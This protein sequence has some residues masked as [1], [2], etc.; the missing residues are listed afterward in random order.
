MQFIVLIA[1]AAAVCG[2]LALYA[3]RNRANH[4]GAS[5]AL[6][7][8]GVTIWAL[9]YA[10][11]LSSATRD[12]KVLWSKVEYAGIV[13]VPVAWV[14][15]ALR[16]TGH[17]LWLTRRNLALLAAPSLVTLLLVWTNEAHGLIWASIR[18]VPGP[19]FVVW[20]AT[21]GPG[22][23]A[24]TAYAY[25][26]LLAGTSLLLWKALR[27]PDL[28]RGQ[29]GAF[30]AG[31]AVPWA[32]NLVYNLGLSPLGIELAP[33]AF[34]VT[35]LTFAGAL[36]RWRLLDIMPVAHDAVFESASDLVIVLDTRHRIVD[37]NQA[38][39]QTIGR[40][41]RELVGQPVERIFARH[42]AMIG[43]F[44]DVIE[45]SEELVLEV[46]GRSLTY[47]L[48]ITPLRRRSGTLGGRLVVLR[49]VTGYKRVEQELR[50]RELEERRFQERLR[51]LVEIS[52]ELSQAETFDELC[53]RAVE[54]GHTRLGFDRLGLWL[55]SPQADALLGTFGI[56]ERGALRDERGQ[57][58]A[59]DPIQA[60]TL[61]RQ[62]P[63]VR[64]LD[65]HD[66]YD[67]RGRVVGCGTL[68]E[69]AIWDRR[70]ILGFL[71]ADNLIR[72]RPITERDCDLFGLYALALGH[73]GTRKRIEEELR[74][75]RDAAE[76]ANQAK[77][78]FLAI[79]SHEI[80]TPMNGVI[81]MADLLLDSGLTPQQREFAQIIRTSGHGLLAIVNE[82]LDFSKIEAGQL[83]LEIHPLDLRACV[84]SAL[85]L[86]R[87]RAIEQGLA[88]TS[89]I[90]PDVPAA[91]LSDS[92]R[93]WQ[94][95]VNLLSNAVK[96]TERGEVA[97]VVA[98]AGMGPEGYELRFT[99][100]DTG[101]GIPTDRMDRLFLA[102]SQ[103]D[104]SIT[105]RYGGTG[106]GLA[107]SKRLA[108]LMGG[109][110]WV[111]SRMGEGSTFSFT[112]RAHP[113]VLDAPPAHAAQRVP[114]PGPEYDAGL[115][116]R[117]PLRILVVEDSRVNQVV[118]LRT[119]ER[120][121]Y[122]P[123]LCENGREA[124]ETL[125]RQVYDV[126]LM[127]VQMPEMDGLEATRRIRREVPLA[128]QP[129]IVAVTA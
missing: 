53:R 88:L 117:L 71:S 94:V 51:E 129:R 106:L 59:M 72:G 97:V 119:L 111:E 65:N 63:V 86:V 19:Q 87:P 62:Y 125:R 34:T 91:I 1:A 58:I 128:R 20:R 79:V 105:R 95:L 9:A 38:A 2:M 17:D 32:G 33:L 48:R 110:M 68:I 26:L 82:I 60:D 100:R 101:I 109:T 70:T 80:R 52:N 43:R 6:L 24:F 76:A 77:S 50:R 13:V 42:L 73:L 126:V 40:H 44:R 11:E 96:F 41:R 103:V 123:E 116:R 85:D 8:L 39:C 67:D 21:Y 5:F 12:A 54:L 15:F 27:S 25:L 75:T 22:F 49:D 37:L 108:E 102:F 46:N 83:E 66:L 127:D 47:T 112:I 120:L 18:L 30:L 115:A 124:L 56:D 35:G 23:W 57:R 98:V 3:W 45:A 89:H 118:A 93:L 90:A 64:R 74:R 113:A 31:T 55:V 107:I 78:S 61:A 69:A 81:G 14:T 122:R 104:A 84:A 99:V 7:M 28:Y 29:A 10:L 114:E 121:G 36:F 16:Y 4:G 92:N